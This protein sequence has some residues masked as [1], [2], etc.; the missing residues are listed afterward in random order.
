MQAFLSALLLLGL[1]LFAGN[2]LINVFRFAKL[3]RQDPAILS[4]VKWKNLA[5]AVSL[6][7][8]A[9]AWELLAIRFWPTIFVGSAWEAIVVLVGAIL[10]SCYGFYFLCELYFDLKRIMRSRRTD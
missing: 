8:S 1:L 4:S 10:I 3:V 5:V 2:L 6:F 7:I 9:L